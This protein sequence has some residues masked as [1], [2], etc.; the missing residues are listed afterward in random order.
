MRMEDKEL[1]KAWMDWE[2]SQTG[3]T[4]TGKELANRMG[5]SASYVSLKKGIYIQS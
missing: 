2:E 3:K 5:K 4:V 1:I